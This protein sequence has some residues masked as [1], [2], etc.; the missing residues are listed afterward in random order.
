MSDAAALIL[1]WAR[2]AVA[3]HGGAF[4]TLHA[5]EIAAPVIA[6]LLARAGVDETLVDAVVVGNA[7]GAGGNPARMLALAAGLPEH[8]AAYSIDTQCCAGLDSV[9]MAAGLLASGNA[10]VVI[11]GGVEAWSRA[12]IRQH[13]PMH[14]GDPAVS[15]E[16]P[17]FAPDPERD[18]DMLMAAARYAALHGYTRVAQDAYAILSHE[19]AIARADT[20][21]A[22]IVAVAGLGRDAYPRHIKLGRAAR[23]PAVAVSDVR[24]ELCGPMATSPGEVSNP[25]SEHVS[26]AAWT[27]RDLAA[28][29][30]LSALSIAPRADGAA[31]VVM[32]SAEACK[33]LGL[34][35]RASV[36]VSSSVGAAP[37]T[38][39]LAAISASRAVLA[40]VGMSMDQMSAIEL[41]DAFAVQAL[42]FCD[43]FGLKHAALNRR[44]GG[45]A[46]G[47]PIG[48]SAA[49]ALVRLL[50]D[51]ERDDAPGAFGLTAS[52]GAGGI[53][54]AAV[55]AR[56]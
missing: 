43:A 50:A 33:R 49:I 53:G 39:M 28:D 6:G 19:R 48:A 12:P 13:R 8:C 40:R 45:L 23:M 56:V 22:E 55:V 10:S 54:A 14:A 44:G 18:P 51:L 30:S 26:N 25:A 17:A 47:H 52:A 11:A 2:S 42:S 34:Q 31:F 21:S 35:A 16:R 15:Y 20:I 41:H 27:T 36:L 5:H 9:T 24:G 29:C 7:L 1:G 37:E 4:K 3:P 32:A 38:P 46:R